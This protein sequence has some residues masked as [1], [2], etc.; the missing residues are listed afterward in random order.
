MG[1]SFGVGRG[2]FGGAKGA[3]DGGD[4]ED[5][6]CYGDSRGVRYEM[7]QWQCEEQCLS[8]LSEA[9]T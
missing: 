2:D 7:E 5:G 9:R 6:V 1:C 4:E 8:L 3:E